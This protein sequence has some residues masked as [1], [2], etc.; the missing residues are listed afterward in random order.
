MHDNGVSGIHHL[1]LAVH[2]SGAAALRWQDVIGV[3]PSDPVP[4]DGGVR[5]R[6]DLENASMYLYSPHRVGPA[7]GS[8][9]A[10]TGRRRLSLA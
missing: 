5:R 1:T 10:G 6:I 9:C 7:C 2:D 3:E 4:V 8:F